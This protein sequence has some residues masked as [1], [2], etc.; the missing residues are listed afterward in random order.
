MLAAMRRRHDSDWRTNVARGATAEP[1]D[2]SSSETDLALRAAR[3]VGAPIA[4]VDLLHGRDGRTYVLEVNAVP[5]WRALAKVTG[6]DVAADV[7][8]FVVD[9]ARKSPR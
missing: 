4:G 8:A 9:P 1:I 2:L 3:A 5:G 6:R 7:L